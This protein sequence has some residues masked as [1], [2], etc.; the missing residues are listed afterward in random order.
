MR[1]KIFNF[2][3]LVQSRQL[4]LIFSLVIWFSSQEIWVVKAINKVKGSTN[5]RL[6]EKF[7]RLV[8]Y[9]RKSDRKKTQVETLY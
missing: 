7:N 2:D 8:S 3:F 9:M 1:I 5:T 4:R 6:K